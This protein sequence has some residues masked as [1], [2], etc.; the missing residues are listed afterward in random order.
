MEFHTIVLMV[1]GIAVGYL[2]YLIYSEACSAAARMHTHLMNT[3]TITVIDGE[4][5]VDPIK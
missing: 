4:V 5:Y 1:C 2:F 3:A